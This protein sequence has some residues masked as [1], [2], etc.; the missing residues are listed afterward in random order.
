MHRT[1]ALV[2]P[3]ALVACSNGA[4]P[5]AGADVRAD[6][7]AASPATLET[8]GELITYQAYEPIIVDAIEWRATEFKVSE[9]KSEVCDP[10]G[11]YV[12][13]DLLFV[14]ERNNG[15]HI[16]DNGVPTNPVPIAFLPV[17]G[18]QGIAA[19]NGILYLSQYT[20]LLAF[21]LRTP[22]K[23][24]FLSRAE[25]V[26]PI[27][28]VFAQQL[29][30]TQF[31]TEYRATPETVT[32]DC[33]STRFG[34]GGWLEGDLI[35]FD[36][37]CTTCSVAGFSRRGSNLSSSTAE[38][39]GQ[40]GSLARFTINNGTLY[41]VDDQS[42][43]TFDLAD[44]TAPNHIGTHRV[45]NGW[46][47][48]TIFPYKNQLYIGSTTGMHIFDVSDPNDPD[49]LSTF[50]HVLSC[51]PVVVQDDLAYV[52]LWGGSTCGSQ[53]DQLEVIDVSDPRRPT[54]L[55]IVPMER[56]HGLGVADG[57]LFLCAYDQ[58]V[59]VFDLT[60]GGLLGE[61]LYED[62]RLLAKDVIVLPQN[63]QLIVF[64]E[65]EAGLEQYRYFE[66]GSLESLSHIDICL[67][68]E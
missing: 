22:R 47:I 46:G 28:G 18:G 9:P 20:D 64:G 51:D 40:G 60:D 14:V 50:E 8:R 58:G 42:L 62:D 45:G 3:F 21:D 25:N 27:Y 68:H 65:G 13:E 29:S 7:P 6:A 63:D 61:Q 30:A 53:Q 31:V 37:N 16:I 26:F 33:G 5:D 67:S 11:F 57:K 39:V 1:L 34:S 12:Y 23:P 52:T 36:V 17:P 66:D 15:L 38:V 48:E 19:R 2:L 10:S 4:E 59:R 24:V 32:V 43:R 44:P 41:V 56:S 55:Q 49:F 54:S 35:F